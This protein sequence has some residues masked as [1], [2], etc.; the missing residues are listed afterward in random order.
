MNGND[1]PAIP[2]LEHRPYDRIRE[3]YLLQEPMLLAAIRRGDRG[4]ARRII[5]HVLVHI[6]SAGEERSDLLKGLLLELVVMISRAAVEAGAVQSEVLGLNFR[7]LTELAGINDDEDLAAWL[8]KTL[9]HVFSTI[10]Q[11]EDFTPPL[12]LG[13]ALDYMRESLHHDI[14]RDDVARHAGISPSHFSR[15]LKERTGR[16]FTELLRQCRVDLA[17]DLLKSP[18]KSLAEIASV[19]GFCDQSYFTRVFQDVKGVT[20]GQFRAA[21]RMNGG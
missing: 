10:E 14:S 2:L 3:L 18:G 1:F 8:R 13:K 7:F 15:L 9:E 5:N 4:E 20:P 17:C 19:C 12:L 6:Y 21:N 16:S 11:Q